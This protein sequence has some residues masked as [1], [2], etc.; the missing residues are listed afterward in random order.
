M[1]DE[2]VGIEIPGIAALDASQP[3]VQA[4]YPGMLMLAAPSAKAR[5]GSL[6]RPKPCAS[7][8]QTVA[9]QKVSGNYAC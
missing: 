2:R 6:Q 1:K 5:Q 4:M 3:Q 9:H 8:I 7:A